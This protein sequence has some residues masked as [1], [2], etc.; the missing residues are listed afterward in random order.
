MVTDMR[1]LQR[2]QRSPISRTAACELLEERE[3]LDSSGLTLAT[4][5]M[6]AALVSTFSESHVR[7]TDT[8]GGYF[9]P[10][11]RLQLD[12]PNGEPTFRLAGDFNGDAITD[13]MGIDPAGDWWLSLN[14]GS[15]L[16][17]LP[18]GAG[19][20]NSQIVG[21]ADFDRDGSED[22][23]SYGADGSLWISSF[24]AGSFTHDLW[25]EFAHPTGW[26]ELLIGDFSG[27]GRPDVLGGAAGGSWWL[28]QNIDDGNFD[29]FHWGRYPDFQWTETLAGEFTG[30]AYS[31]VIALAP[32]KTWWIWEGTE[33]GFATSRYFGHWKMRSEWSDVSVGDFNGDGTDDVIGRAEDGTLWVGQTVDDILNTWQ[34][35]TGWIQRAE[36]SQVTIMDVNGDGL[37]DQVGHARDDTWWYALNQGVNSR[38]L[39]FYWNDG[40]ASDFVVQNFRLAE[41]VDIIDAFPAGGLDKRGTGTVTQQSVDPTQVGPI[42]KRSISTLHN[43][44]YFES[45]RNNDSDTVNQQSVPPTDDSQTEE[46]E[47]DRFLTSIVA[48]L[49]GDSVMLDGSVSDFVG[50]EATSK[51]GFLSLETIEIP[52]IGEVP[53]ADPFEPATGVILSN[54]PYYIVIGSLGR[55]LNLSGETLTSLRYSGPLDDIANDLVINLGVDATAMRIDVVAG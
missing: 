36:W 39:N 51:G 53:I 22:V 55:T 49:V 10:T 33:S 11:A 26:T 31:D 48:R 4:P 5:E 14:D 3:L 41:G 7:V 45:L 21:T 16:Y 54:T 15:Q 38:F 40:A 29:N 1:Q 50:I 42:R 46:A 37:D 23:L 35:A 17:A 34:W 12:A 47:D 30:D 43:L 18:A 6:N 9:I 19:L 8:T 28:A 25:G 52:T 27:N 24:R 32:D 13:M 44:A 20:P 2:R